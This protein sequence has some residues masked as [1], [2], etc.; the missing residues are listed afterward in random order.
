MPTVNDVAQYILAKQD[1]D[2]GDTISN[3]KLQKL[4][5]Y[6][7]GFC[8]AMTGEPLFDEEI[9]AWE[10]G[11]VSPD[12][13]HA[14]K[15]Y[16]AGSIPPPEKSVDEISANFREEQL[17][18]IDEVL[19]VY[20]QFSAWKLRNLTHEEPTWLDRYGKTDC[21]ITKPAMKEYFMTR[22]LDDDEEDTHA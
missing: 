3:M 2:A 17:E 19:D 13:Y 15:T 6:A 9:H 18:V 20:G 10:H 8:L 1:I 22:L 11:P 7:Q 21:E 5:Y 4:V 14:Y 12:L 16:G